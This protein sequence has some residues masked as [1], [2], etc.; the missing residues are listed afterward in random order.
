[1]KKR[2]TDSPAKFIVPLN[3]DS[4]MGRMLVMPSSQNRT[5]EILFVYGQHST[6]E[7]WF[8]LIQELSKY[9]SVTVPDLPGFGGMDSLY[10]IGQKPT[11]DALAD[12]LAAFIKL[13]YK[14]RRLTIVGLSFGFVVVTRMLQRYPELTKRVDVMISIVGF[15]HKDDFTFSRGRYNLYLWG[16]RFFSLRAPAWFY[17]NVVLQPIFLRLVYDK[18]HNSQERFKGL[19]NDEFNETM[20]TEINLWRVNDC[21]TW[22]ATVVAFLKLDNC[23]VRL[24]LPVWHVSVRADHYFDQRLVE[25]HMKVIFNDFH[26]FKSNIDTHAPSVIAD[27]KTAAPLVPPALRRLLSNP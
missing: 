26:G 2:P 12:Y 21:R 6:I 24:D 25:Q 11:I 8:G 17:R 19:S 16:S 23:R 14:R 4:L 10:K 22:A 7:R 18:G 5:R 13:H 27:A 1:M 9:G 3:M 20:N 15:A